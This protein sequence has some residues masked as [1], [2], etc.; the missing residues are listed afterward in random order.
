[1]LGSVVSFNSFGVKSVSV[2]STKLQDAIKESWKVKKTDNSATLVD[3]EEKWREF[4]LY[5]SNTKNWC[6]RSSALS[7]LLGDS[8]YEQDHKLL[9]QFEQGKAYHSVFQKNI[10]PSL[11]DRFLGGWKQYTPYD[12]DSN[13][14]TIDVETFKGEKPV[15][16]DEEERSI[17]VPWSVRPDGEWEYVEPKVRMLKYRVVVKI[18]GILKWSDNDLEIFELK[19]EHESARDSLDLSIGGKPRSHHVD[20]CLI[21][22]WATGIRK[23]RLVYL[24]KGS[25]TIDILEH[26]ISYDESRVEVLKQIALKCVESVEKCDKFKIENNWNDVDNEMVLTDEEKENRISKAYEFIN[27]NFDRCVECPMKSKG[28]AEKCPSRDLCFPKK[29]KK[30]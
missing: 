14:Q 9:Y 26:E 7:A 25:R 18:D 8:I 3:N 16:E 15:I 28:R 22:M 20:Q 10:L 13:I 6:P 11:G 12:T 17:L 24:F 19:T 30:K 4:W 29:V 21:G 2:S 27:S 23:A 5:A 1:M